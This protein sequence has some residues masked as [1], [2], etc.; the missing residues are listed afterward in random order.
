LSDRIN[1]GPY[2]L[3]MLGLSV[4][5]IAA[6]GAQVVFDLGPDTT[7]ILDISDTAICAVFFLDFL[8][9]LIRADNRLQ[10]FVRWGWIDLISSIPTIDIFRW[11]R[12]ARIFRILRVLRG[13]R[14]TRLL[15]SFALERRA[16]SAF[17]A[18]VFVAI[19]VTIFGSIAV[20]TLERPVEGNIK[21][22]ADALWWSFVTVTTV[23]YGDHYPLS[24]WGRIVAAAM[25]VAGISLFGTF[26]AYIAS[27]FLSP[28]ESEQERELSALRHEISEL[29]RSIERDS[30]SPSGETSE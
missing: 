8:R 6:L 12:A 9:S 14:A 27:A 24:S 3:F 16:A 15:S 25:M 4:Y 20:L 30:K 23:G 29:R 17:W 19:L 2:Q 1:T 28:G 13:F 7:E 26:T 22:A 5:V 21:T 18:A 10:Y 11:G